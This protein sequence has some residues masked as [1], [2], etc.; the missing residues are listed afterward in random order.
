MEEPPSPT[1]S[2]MVHIYIGCCTAYYIILSANL[3][4]K[5][6][7]VTFKG[8]YTVFLLNFFTRLLV[9][10]LYYIMIIFMKPLLHK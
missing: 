3:F 4:Q 1:C 5:V 8:K 9:V 6:V 2:K 7:L 10:V